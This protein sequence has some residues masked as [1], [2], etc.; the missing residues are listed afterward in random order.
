MEASEDTIQFMPLAKR[1]IVHGVTGSI[2]AYKAAYLSSY[3]IKSGAIVDVILSQSAAQFVGSTTFS[4]ITHRPVTSDLWNP[5]SEMS[6][7]HVEL[8]RR[9]DLLIIAPATANTI[10]KLAL[11]IADDA[12][13]AT[14]LAVDAPIIIAPAMDFGMFQS[15]AVQRNVRSLQ[16]TGV[17]FAGPVKGRLASGISGTGRMMEPECIV[18]HIRWLL[19]KRGDYAGKHVIVTAAGTHESID[20]VRH[21]ANRSSGRM[22]FAIAEAARD[23]GAKV[24]LIT[25]PSALEAPELVETVRVDT[26]LNMRDAVDRYSSDADLLIMAA[27]VA[28]FRPAEPRK[29]KIKKKDAPN[30]IRLI[31]NPDIA[32]EAEGRKLTKVVFAAETS[33]DIMEAARKAKAKGAAFTV[34]NDISDKDSGFGSETCR[35]VFVRPD[36]TREPQPLLPKSLLAHRILDSAL[37]T[38]NIAFAKG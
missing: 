15:A 7:A 23:R 29:E 25:G 31:P 13:G 11:G 21:I 32:A 10:A 18:Q 17:H 19:G 27:A 28:D 14:F 5:N 16:E 35:A 12:L 38:V 2:A 34:L 22:G 6:I 3:L 36:G 4:A 9:A 24:T 26:A 8:G 20:I 37:A 33:L 30:I 1:K